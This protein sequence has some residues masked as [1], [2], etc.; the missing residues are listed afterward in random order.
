MFFDT[1]LDVRQMSHE[2]MWDAFIAHLYNAANMMK[3][4]LMSEYILYKT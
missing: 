4:L 3:S 1:V 2:R